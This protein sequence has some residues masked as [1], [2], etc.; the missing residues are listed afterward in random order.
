MERLKIKKYFIWM[1]ILS[2][3][4]FFLLPILVGLILTHPFRR[5]TNETPSDYNLHFEEVEFQSK[6][7]QVVLRGWW[8]P[9]EKPTSKTV[10][11]A[12]GYTDER[13]QK[14]INGLRI[15]TSLQ[16]KGYNVLMFDFR[17][18]GKSGGR[19]TGIGFYEQHDLSSAV[20]YVIQEKKQEE[21]VLLGWSMGGATCLLVGSVHPQIKGV[22]ADSPFHDLQTYLED[23]LNVWSKLPKKPFTSIILRSMKHL[24]K[25]DP[26]EVSPVMSVQKGKSTNYLLIHGKNDTK[27]PF[28]SSEMIFEQIPKEN[29][30][31][32]WLTEHGHITTF[33]EEPESYT[34]KIIEFVD[35]TFTSNEK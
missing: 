19:R 18:S 27:V 2:P 15:V 13:S 17:N 26:K 25:I 11:T 14:K 28:S 29:E 9:A 1:L 23:N 34:S 30:K 20:D 10:V 4:I 32:L 16:E 6:L 3:F 7:D 8:I 21:I 12:H 31:T 24:L 35:K 22:I 33:V 5:K